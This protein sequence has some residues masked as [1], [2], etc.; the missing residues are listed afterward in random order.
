MERATSVEECLYQNLTSSQLMSS[1]TSALMMQ[2]ASFPRSC[3]DTSLI[4]TPHKAPQPT[5]TTTV[6]ANNVPVSTEKEASESGNVT[7]DNVGDI[8]LTPQ[9]LLNAYHRTTL[10]K[11]IIERRRA[12]NKKTPF[13]SRSRSTTATTNNSTTSYSTTTKSTSA[14]TRSRTSCVESSTPVWSSQGKGSCS[15]TKLSP[16]ISHT[17]STSPAANFDNAPTS[18]EASSA[19]HETAD[20]PDATSPTSV[21]GEE[22]HEEDNE[23]LCWDHVVEMEGVSDSDAEEEAKAAPPVKQSYSWSSSY[24]RAPPTP[25]APPLNLLECLGET[26]QLLA[27]DERWMCPN[28]EEKRDA[29]SNSQPA[30]IPPCLLITFKRFSM[31]P[32][33]FNLIKNNRLC[34]FPLKI[35]MRQFLAPE[36][37]FA[38]LAAKS[39]EEA[40][41]QF[42]LCPTLHQL[43]GVVPLSSSTTTNKKATSMTPSRRLEEFLSTPLCEPPVLP[44][45]RE[46]LHH[47]PRNLQN[48]TTTT[49]T[50]VTPETA[51]TLTDLQFLC[52]NLYHF[53]RKE[54]PESCT[55][56]SQS[57]ASYNST[58]KGNTIDDNKAEEGGVE[59]QSTCTKA[60]TR[61]GSGRG[62]GGRGKRGRE[63]SS[64][65]TSSPCISASHTPFALSPPNATDTLTAVGTTTTTS[66]GDVDTFLNDSSDDEDGEDDN[67]NN[68]NAEGVVV[69]PALSFKYA[70]RGVVYHSGSLNGGHY[71]AACYSSEARQWLNYN[72]SSVS[73]CEDFQIEDMGAGE[74]KVRSG[75]EEKPEAFGYHIKLPS[76]TQ[77]SSSTTTL[78][79]LGAYH[80]PV[81]NAFMV[82]YER[83][84]EDE[85]ASIPAH[86]YDYYT[87]SSEENGD[88]DEVGAVKTATSGTT[89]T[90]AVNEVRTFLTCLLYTSPS[91][92]DS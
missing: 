41:T 6:T 71:T 13:S 11:E 46:Q 49:S 27:R 82:F 61:G 63:T 59:Q 60:A 29:L 70:L 56:Y 25:A 85:F 57:D 75:I 1:P 16:T 33:T 43:K 44:S 67:N 15:P 54:L 30:I 9:M 53:L 31:C 23:D 64:N 5:S 10:L 87:S 69:Q 78:N 7:T 37:S 65:G 88:D 77:T 55:G 83:V 19:R 17:I 26:Q 45:T 42:N 50:A 74:K 8:A 47:D 92:R 3:S 52:P 12:N 48:T 51:S 2:A 86:K 72:D 91:P 24:S 66:G 38:P 36:D 90:T 79:N 84:S 80:P 39:L 20:E 21:L 22:V 4:S 81:G 28:C 62:L 68:T 89:S 73:T 58:S 35:D 32:T 18:P 76:K 34:Y 40:D 14:A